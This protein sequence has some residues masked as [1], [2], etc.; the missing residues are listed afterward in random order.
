MLSKDLLTVSLNGSAILEYDRNKILSKKQGESLDLMN[1]KLDQGITLNNQF[2]ANP[3]KEQRIEFVAAN[4]VSA[5]MN[6]E[7]TL[8]AAS[9]AYIATALPDLKQLK[10][11]EQDGE[12]IIALDFIRPY[13]DETHLTFTP[14]EKLTRRPH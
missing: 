10:A 7:D 13:Q 12:I 5:I 9:C 1:D 4:L 8:A 6:E 14:I 11:I 3:T 2:L